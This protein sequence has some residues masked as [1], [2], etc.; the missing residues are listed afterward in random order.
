MYHGGR[1][2]ESR[3]H[4]RRSNKGGRICSEGESTGIK[5]TCRVEVDDRKGEGGGYNGHGQ[6]SE[7]L[8]HGT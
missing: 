2:E 5:G 8:Y 4:G 7:R 1:S 6:R 3:L